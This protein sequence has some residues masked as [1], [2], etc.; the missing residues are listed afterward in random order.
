MSREEG[1]KLVK[2]NDGK[3]PKSLDGF[4]EM[5]NLTDEDFYNIVFKHVVA[6]HEPE[7]MPKLMSK[8]NNF[9]PDDINRWF[10][11]FK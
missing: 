3:R 9:I 4:L 8:K 2:E 7:S 1:E 10:N 6:P 11:K 5:L